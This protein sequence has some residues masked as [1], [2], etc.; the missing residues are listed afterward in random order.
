MKQIF[1]TFHVSSHVDLKGTHM[2]ADVIMVYV[3][4]TFNQSLQAHLSFLF[5]C[6]HVSR[7]FLKYLYY[8]QF[9]HLGSVEALLRVWGNGGANA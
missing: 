3:I 7:K 9:S 6:I 5:T 2:L 1:M 4:M 8:Q